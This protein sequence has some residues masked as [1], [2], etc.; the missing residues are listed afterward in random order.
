MSKTKRRR[1]G[2]WVGP[3]RLRDYLER[4]IEPTQEWPPETAGVY[5]VSRDPWPDE[6]SAACGVLYVGGNPH[7][8]TLFRQ[9]IGF[10]V[11]DMFGF[12][13]DVAGSHSGGIS[14]WEWCFANRVHPLDLY[15]GWITGIECGRCTEAD[16][17]ARL[18]PTLSRKAPARCAEHAAV[19]EEA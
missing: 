9:R 12:W 1:G 5:V 2:R 4:C 11:K 19:A 7:V 16:L 14:L 10:L 17:F 3:F 13:G 8:P 6:P 18:E 15:L